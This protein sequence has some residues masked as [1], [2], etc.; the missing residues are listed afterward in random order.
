[1]DHLD[2][3]LIPELKDLNTNVESEYNKIKA[4]TAHFESVNQQQRD[5]LDEI[6]T[7]ITQQSLL[8][9]IMLS[10]EAW[11]NTFQ[12]KTC[13]ELGFNYEKRMLSFM[14]QALE[15]RKQSL[16]NL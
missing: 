12:K 3:S 1:V 7:V 13:F 6:S 4:L 11:Y 10:F 9:N 16:N 8:R 15:R 14:T 5:Y 2:N